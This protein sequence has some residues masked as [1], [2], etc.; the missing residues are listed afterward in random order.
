[1]KMTDDEGLSVL[2]GG[3]QVIRS[4]KYVAGT[5]LSPNLRRKEVISNGSS[6][7]YGILGTG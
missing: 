1:M 5:P 2:N 4:D 6:D 3:F 7:F